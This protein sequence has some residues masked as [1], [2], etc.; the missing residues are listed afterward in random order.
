MFDEDDSTP[1]IR[2]LLIDEHRLARCA[3]RSLIASLDGMTLIGEAEDAVEGGHLS[4]AG[5][6][7]VVI[8]NVA[9]PELNGLTVTRELLGANSALS[10]VVLAM[11]ASDQHAAL[12]LRLGA[13]GFLLKEADLSHF[14][15]AVQ[16]AARGERFTCPSLG[17]DDSGPTAVELEGLLTPRQRQVFQLVAEGY[18]NRE[19]AERLGISVKTVESHREALMERLGVRRP[20]GLIR[21]AI[22]LGLLSP[23]R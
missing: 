11:Y 7:D 22:R 5:K 6:P 12:S 19:I 16:R 8:V 9:M 3:F 18:R 13:R 15:T 10:V 2:I 1:P 23:E 17:D 21:E 14:V 20:A 4:R